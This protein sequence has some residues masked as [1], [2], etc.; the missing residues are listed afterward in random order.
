MK[1]DELI[2]LLAG[3][4][5][6]VEPDAERRRFAMALGWGAFGAT[7]LMALLLGVREDLARAAWLPMFWVKLGYP[8]LIA[9]GALLLAARL[10]RPGAKPGR[11]HW[12][13]LAPV[14]VIWLLAAVMLVRAQPVERQTLLF[15]ET[16][17]V[18]PFYIGLLSVPVF[19]A[20]F[21]AMRGLAPTRLALAGAAAGLFAGALATTAYALHCP[22]M[23]PAFLGSW[24]LLGMLIP[25]TLGAVLGPRLLRW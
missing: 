11:V 8:A 24:Y 23:S 9:A 15:G 6:P 19:A 1:T 16:W 18:C 20:A 14:A 10:S 5:Q 21:W 17:I 12:L 4:A 3:G 13:V 25:T 7:L 22:E 2:T